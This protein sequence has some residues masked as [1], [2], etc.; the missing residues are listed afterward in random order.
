MMQFL[1]A[2]AAKLPFP[3]DSFDVVIGSP[4]YSDARL[5]LEAGQDPGISRSPEEWVEWM[6]TVTQ[7]ACRVSRGLVVWIA[8]GVTRDWCYRPICE[9]LQWE[10]YKRGGQLWRPG[11]WHRVGIPGSGGRQWL[12]ADVEYAMAFTKCKGEIPFADN[13]ANGHPPKWAPGGDMSYRNSEGTRRNQWGHSGTGE[14]AERRVDGERGDAQRP[15]HTFLTN[16]EHAAAA[17][18][19]PWGKRGRGNNLGGRNADGSKKLGTNAGAKQITRRISCGKGPDGDTR[20]DDVY[21]PPVL[22]NPGTLVDVEMTSDEILDLWIAQAE[23]EGMDVP[24]CLKGIKV[25]GGLMGS[26]LAH[27]NEAPYPLK[28]AKWFI[29]MLA[30][31]GGSVCDPFSGSGTTV[32]AAVELGR[33]GVGCDIRASQVDLAKRR[34]RDVQPESLFGG[35]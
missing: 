14:T 21:L 31:P 33:S 17:D 16:A 15:S 28:L 10:W 27:L 23:A 2:D 6:L 9:G 18:P 12:R 25:G 32:H 35:E 22:A 7:E 26:D 3:D 13:T 29:R 8:A 34:C 5:Y 1:Q 20:Q 19:D 11:F 4:P 24:Q 30:P